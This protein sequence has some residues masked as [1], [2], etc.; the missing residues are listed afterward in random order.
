MPIENPELIGI[1]EEGVLV[2]ARSRVNFVGPTVTVTDNP[3][4]N[5][6]DVT[7]GGYPDDSSIALGT[8][9]DGQIWLNS[10]ALLADAEVTGKIIGASDHNAYAA[11]SVILSNITADGDFA[12]LVNNGGNSL[13]ALWIDASTRIVDIG[14]KMWRV[15]INGASGA[16]SICEFFAVYPP[17]STA[18][19]DATIGRVLF[20]PVGAVTVPTGTAPVVATLEVD[21]PVITATGTVTVATAIYIGGAPTEGTRNYGL[22]SVAAIGVDDSHL[23]S[24]GTDNDQV[25]VNDAAGRAANAAFTGVVV[26]TGVYAIIPANSAVFSNVTANGDMVWLLNDIAGNSWEYMRFD[27]SAKKIYIGG[28]AGGTTDIDTVIAGKTNANLIVTDAGLDTIGMLTTAASNAVLNIGGSWTAGNLGIQLAA[29]FAN[30]SASQSGQPQEIFVVPTMGATN[31][32][33]WT[34]TIGLTGYRVRANLSSPGNVYTLTGI[35][36]LHIQDAINKGS[37]VVTA[38]YGIYIEAL[39]AGSTNWAIYTAGAGNV[40]FAAD[41]YMNT[42]AQDI[43]IKSA[44]AA[45]L[46]VKDASVTYLA[47]DTSTQTLGMIT[48]AVTRQTITLDK[49]YADV[50]SNDS[51]GAV[52]INRATQTTGASANAVYGLV[53]R[54]AVPAANTQN[55]TAAVGMQGVIGSIVITTGSTG[56]ITGAAHFNSPNAAVAGATLTNQYGYHCEALTGATNNFQ[57]GLANGGTEPAAAPTDH[58]GIYCVDVAGSTVLGWVQETAVATGATLS[59]HKVAVRINGASYNILLE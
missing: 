1:Y 31:T 17:A 6:I 28:Q 11:N 12:V 55:W 51:Y 9:G 26:G 56:T 39:T 14:G 27:G 47:I 24:L 22:Y 15:Q 37:A 35:T 34:N 19:A 58:I 53:G 48:A 45:A 36:G 43:I 4:S 49:T 13:E 29:T 20:A 25:M 10:A 42:A 33:N 16:E 30:T 50:G 8:H 59:G 2:G 23:F 46:E 52:F 5:R 21:E 38:Q 40:N 54:A 3:T 44:T 7:V 18:T 32:Q 41:L 57:I